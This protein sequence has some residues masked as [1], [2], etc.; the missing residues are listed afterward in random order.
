MAGNRFSC[1]TMQLHFGLSEAER[2]AYDVCA[3]VKGNRD[4]YKRMLRLFHE[5]VD[6]GNPRTRRD[7]VVSFA[8]DMG[9]PVSVVD[10]LKHDHN[11]FAGLSRYAVMLRPRLARTLHFRK[12]K[13]DDIDLIP[14]WHEVV[15]PRTTF[16]AK[17]RREAE[18]L[19]E[20][21]DASAA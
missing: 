4:S 17:N 19:V 2:T 10:D 6:S 8:R 1:E 20:I 13:L 14:I 3:W 15:D 5:Q 18:H 21:G 9:L 7:D 11:L 16:L 12:S